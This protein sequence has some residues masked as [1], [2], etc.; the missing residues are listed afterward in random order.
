MPCAAR[1]P[2]LSAPTVWLTAPSVGMINTLETNVNMLENSRAALGSYAPVLT[3]NKNK[4]IHRSEVNHESCIA[5]RAA[6]P[7]GILA[8]KVSDKRLPCLFFSESIGV[9]PAAIKQDLVVHRVKFFGSTPSPLVAITTEQADII[10]L[11]NITI[12]FL[13]NK[14]HDFIYNFQFKLIANNISRRIY[15]MIGY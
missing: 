13:K 12:I 1:R 7:V 4:N 11:I 15:Q 5:A 8:R 6:E 10:I 9:A 14:Q 3:L 2:L